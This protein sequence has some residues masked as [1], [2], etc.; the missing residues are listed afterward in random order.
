MQKKK[1]SKKNILMCAFDEAVCCICRG[2]WDAPQV[3]SF[4][5]MVVICF[6]NGPMIYGLSL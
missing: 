1:K 3:G 5:S 2:L 6:S 4:K